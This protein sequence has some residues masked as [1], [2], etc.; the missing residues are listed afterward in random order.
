MVIGFTVVIGTRAYVCAEYRTIH[1]GYFQ[2]PGNGPS[3]PFRFWKQAD[4]RADQSTSSGYAITRQTVSVL[5]RS[6]PIA[7]FM[8]NYAKKADYKSNEEVRRSCLGGTRVEF[9]QQIYAWV[10]AACEQ[11]NTTP[12]GGIVLWINGLGGTGKTTVARSVSEWCEKHGVLGGSFFC[13]KSDAECS[14]PNLIFLT[15]CRQLCAH[16]E[17]FKTKVEAVL[18]RDPNIVNSGPYRQFEELIVEPLEALDSPFPRSVFVLDALDECKN[19]GAKSTILSVIAKFIARIAKFLFFIITSRPEDHITALF[20]AS[21]KDSLKDTTKPLLMHDIPL[22]LAL[23]DIRLYLD[24]EFEDHI[25]VLSIGP[26]WP[27]AEEKDALVEQSRG[28]FIYV[29]TVIKFVMDRNYRDPKGRMRLLR[30]TPSSSSTPHQFLSVLYSKILVASYEHAS[31]ELVSKLSDVLGTVVLAQ[32]PLSP[33]SVA[34]LVG[35]NV[36][37]IRN[38]LT[39]LHSVLHIPDD[40]DQP[41]RIIHPTF[42]E[43]L[44]T[45]PET[46]PLES[47]D[48]AS[49]SPHL[50]LQPAAQHRLLFS[51][52][53]VAMSGALKRDM[54]GMRYPALFLSE[55]TDLKQKV[56]RAIKPHVSYAC[57]FWGRHLRDG[58]K[59]VATSDFLLLSDFVH[60]GLLHW[61]EAC[62]LLETVDT[63]V[64]AL[65]AARNICQVSCD[66]F[67]LPLLRVDASADFGRAIHRPRTAAR[68]LLAIRP[69]LLAVYPSR[70]A[71]DL[72]LRAQHRANQQPRWE[73]VRARTPTRT[74]R[75][76]RFSQPLGALHPR[77]HR[78]RRQQRIHS[79]VFAGWGLLR[80]R[81]LG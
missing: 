17:P 26:D 60:K 35:L 70:A 78:T 58:M 12:D 74:C 62:C 33:S 57:R 37:D 34:H 46:P 77:V 68:R 10:A 49:I 51:R 69:Q 81:R 38:T 71:A 15:L 5:T 64:F 72:P 47:S 43:F 76:A 3:I 7:A 50:R 65:D 21:R 54:I 20:K 80:H 67:D 25:G 40:D 45:L 1:R 19:E 18:A 55:V 23:K 63:V 73:Q 41:I 56:N 4:V 79:C 27:S 22:K 36:D 6:E 14:D 61:I 66:H 28:L 39:G 59:D 42:P 53:I 32:E 52:C 2:G 29:A 8:P 9:L 11:S 30:L 31:P 44:L 48:L 13:S 75:E 24:H 16:H